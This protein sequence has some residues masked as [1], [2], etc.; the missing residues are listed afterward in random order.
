MA[1]C[2]AQRHPRSR[3]GA[4]P[5]SAVAPSSQ[6]AAG[7]PGWRDACNTP[8]NNTIWVGDE[9]PFPGGADALAIEQRIASVIRWNALA[10][11][12]RANR[13]YGVQPRMPPGVEEGIRRGMYCL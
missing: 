12:V 1:R 10:M 4:R 5:F 7:R 11:V 3:A 9:P 6:C 13:A 2:L 8:Y